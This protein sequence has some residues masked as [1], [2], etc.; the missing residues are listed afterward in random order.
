M[1]GHLYIKNDGSFFE[2]SNTRQFEGSTLSKL[3]AYLKATSV[4]PQIQAV[5]PKFKYLQACCSEFQGYHNAVA[6]FSVSQRTVY[7]NPC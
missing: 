5:F 1:H 3:V 4:R 7:K 6:L 2:V